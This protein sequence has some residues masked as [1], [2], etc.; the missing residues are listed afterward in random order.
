MRIHPL[1][2]VAAVALV[3]ALGASDAKAM[4]LFARKFGVGC[5]TCHT[6]IPAL[7]ETG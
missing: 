4:P 1:V 6:T 3:I 7:N 2:C 5:E